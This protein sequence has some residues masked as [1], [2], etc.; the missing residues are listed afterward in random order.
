M[1]REIDL[2]GYFPDVM[3]PIRQ[4][5]AI[6]TVENLEFH[7]LAQGLED[8]QNSAFIEESPESGVKRW[9]EMLELTPKDTDDLGVR[10]FRIL[11]RMNERIPYTMTTLRQQL[12]LLC[13]ENGY[14]VELHNKEYTVVIRLALTAKKKQEEVMEYLQRVKPANILI[15]LSLLY[16][17]H[18][19]LSAFSHK[20]LQAYTQA[21]LRNEVISVGTNKELQTQ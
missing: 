20:Q 19:T 11:A 5:Q 17:Q 13:G 9:E 2:V 18:K 1:E 4:F 12:A 15:D 7:Q 10:K 6:G 14:T 16:N 3:K 8:I 21:Q